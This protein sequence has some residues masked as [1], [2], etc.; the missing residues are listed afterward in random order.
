VTNRPVITYIRVSTSQQGRSGLGIE[1]QRQALTNFAQTEG[2]TV[3]GVRGTL[4]NPKLSVARKSAVEAVKRAE[5]FRHAIAET[6]HLSTQGAADE[7]NHRG[8]ATA[9]GRRWHAM[10]VH[11]ARRHLGL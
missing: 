1:A 4:G 9:G 11:R 3:A 2:F 5:R 6:T 10:Q 8:I 7:L